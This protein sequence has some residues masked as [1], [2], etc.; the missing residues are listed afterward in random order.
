VVLTI[1]ATT[2]GKGDLAVASAKGDIRLYDKI[3][4]KAKTQLPGLGGLIFIDD[5]ND[6]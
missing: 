5:L 6:V 2:T 3:D 1:G 4:K